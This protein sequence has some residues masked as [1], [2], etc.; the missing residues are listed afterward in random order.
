MLIHLP[1]Y[2]LFF[3]QV[4]PFILRKRCHKEK[5]IFTFNTL[6]Q[7]HDLNETPDSLQL[8]PPMKRIQLDIQ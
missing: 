8:V 4:S 7:P 2:S 5:I 6:I 1:P 3:I